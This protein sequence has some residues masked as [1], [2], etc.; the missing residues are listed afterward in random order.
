MAHFAEIDENNIVLRILVIPN[1]QEERGEEYLS[2]DVGLGGRW[3]QTSYNNNM[4]GVYAMIGGL[5]YEPL[6]IFLSP[7]PFP[8]WNINTEQG[9]WEAPIPR[10]DV[11]NKDIIWNETSQEWVITDPITKFPF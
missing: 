11:P 3:I 10:P 5:Y 4:R 9:I 8:S 7:K 1:E 2:V 6:D